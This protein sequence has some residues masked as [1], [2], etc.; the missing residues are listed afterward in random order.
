MAATGLPLIVV[1]TTI[2]ISDGYIS[3]QTGAALVTAG[4][5]SVLLLPNIALRLLRATDERQAAL[6]PVAI[7]QSR[8]FERWRE[9]R[10]WPLG[11]S[12]RQQTPNL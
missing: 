11:N 2:G 10:L 8:G 7:P 3:R 1:I 9:S 4:M 12:N 5:L 6:S